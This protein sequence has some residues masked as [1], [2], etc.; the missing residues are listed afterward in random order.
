MIRGFIG[1]REAPYIRARVILPRFG[2][3]WEIDFL[4]DT[5]ADDTCLH[6]MDVLNVGVPF[7]RLGN[8]EISTGI[9]GGASYYIEPGILAFEDGAQ[10]RLYE[11]ELPIAKPTEDNT[12]IPSL[13]GR[14]IINRWS[15]LYEPINGRLECRVLEA[16]L[17]LPA[18]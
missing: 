10:F 1:E 18:S 4:M 14:N 11:V 12:R 17:T 16:D 5:G 9:G 8:E 6:P 15:V 13:L 3:E 7:E 2:L